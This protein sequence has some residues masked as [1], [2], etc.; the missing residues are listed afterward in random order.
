MTSDLDTKFPEIYYDGTKDYMYEHLKNDLTSPLKGQTYA[1]IFIFAMALAKRDRLVPADLKKQAKMP[2]NAF[3]SNMRTLMRS[4]MIDEKR[5]VYSIKDN[6]ELRNICQ[7]YANAGIDKLY[8]SVTNNPVGTEGED[9][10]V[11]LIQSKT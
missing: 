9:V 11:D 1:T 6:L 5:D 7:K 8:W 10:L 4:I 3:D 2:P